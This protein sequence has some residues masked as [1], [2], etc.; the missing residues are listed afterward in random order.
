MTVM[1]HINFEVIAWNMLCYFPQTLVKLDS[2][3][4]VCWWFPREIK[5]SGPYQQGEVGG[6]RGRT[7]GTE[8]EF[9]IRNKSSIGDI[10]IRGNQEDYQAP[11]NPYRLGRKRKV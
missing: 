7:K 6:G 3:T 5:G 10:G 2:H 9:Q 4:G 1:S 11:K 8:G